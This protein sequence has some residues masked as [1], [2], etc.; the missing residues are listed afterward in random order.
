MKNHIPRRNAEWLVYSM[1]KK[2]F[3]NSDNGR[4]VQRIVAPTRYDADTKQWIGYPSNAVIDP[5]LVISRI[6]AV[7]LSFEHLLG[8]NH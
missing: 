7:L 1:E 8:D 5:E 2:S 3:R 4:H 6:E